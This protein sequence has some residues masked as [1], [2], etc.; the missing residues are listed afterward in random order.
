M[1]ILKDYSDKCYITAILCELSYNFYST[2]YNISLLPTILGSSI[3]T[4]INSSEIDN[5]ILKKVNICINGVNT[6]ILALIN[7]YKVSD[8]INAFNNSRIKFNKLNHLIESVVNKHTDKDIDKG[9]IEN[10]INEYDK[11]FEDISY[12]FPNHIRQKVIKKF[13]GEKKLPN[14]LEIDYNN[15]IKKDYI[16]NMMSDIVST[17]V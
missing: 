6:I 2:I 15:T 14:S 3:L 8:R 13:G 17:N 4:I 16:N 7:S 5:E 9:I 11:L 12:R 1:E 10:I